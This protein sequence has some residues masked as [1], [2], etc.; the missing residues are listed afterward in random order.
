M[1][2]ENAQQGQM[3]VQRIYV[4]DISFESPMTPKIFTDANW[5]P[6]INLNLDSNADKL[7]V[8][9]AYEVS[10]RITVTAK[11]NEGTAY[12]VEVTQ[13]GIFIL[14]DFNEQEF[15]YMLGSYLP[16]LLFPF[17]REAI[18]DIVTRGGF[19]Q[20]LL[21]PVNFDALFA[22][23]SQQPTGETATAQG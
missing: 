11:H 20:M 4:K 21:A 15:G 6:Q 9:D 18:S 5:S 10:L 14:K 23:S 13:A 8:N 19:P 7:A 12:L 1:T 22:A 3:H 16:N 2:Q 17:A